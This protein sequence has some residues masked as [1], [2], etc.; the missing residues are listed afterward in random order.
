MWAKK[1]DG[2]TKI[3]V[4]VGDDPAFELMSYPSDLPI[5]NGKLTFPL[6]PIAEADMIEMLPT[7]NKPQ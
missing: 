3:M 6:M 2:R 1:E 5:I 4:V 7:N